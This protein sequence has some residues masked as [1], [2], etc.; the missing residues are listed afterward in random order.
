MTPAGPRFIDVDASGRFLF[1]AQR[2]G[3][4]GISDRRGERSFDCRRCAAA[5]AAN[6][7]TLD[8]DHNGRCLFASD[9]VSWRCAR[10]FDQFGDGRAHG[11]DRQSF[12]GGRF[13]SRSQSASERTLR[14]R[15]QRWRQHR[16][17]VRDHDHDCECMRIDADWTA[18]LRRS[19][20]IW[21]HQHRHRADWSI[22]VRRKR[23]DRR[24]IDH[25]DQSE[26]G[27]AHARRTR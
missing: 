2:L 19:G 10:L 5:I 21:N 6:A 24:R 8:V 18:C 16:F 22:R 13:A 1:A 12:R 4:F 26:F 25:V 27:R 14:V 11:R 9:N 17:R 3:D 20:G 15:D 23:G 7:D